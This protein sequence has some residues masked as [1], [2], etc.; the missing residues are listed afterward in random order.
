MRAVL[1]L[2]L[3]VF[4]FVALQTQSVFR[5]PSGRKYHAADC[6]TVKNVSEKISI[7]EA[8]AL[9]LTACL[10]CHPGTAEPATKAPQGEAPSVQ[11]KG[12]TLSG[13][14]C[15]LRTRIGNGYCSKHQPR[16]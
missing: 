3:F 15:K 14:R 1:F 5:T 16:E 9:G 10:V 4:G 6:R 13:T 2:I 11:C 8:R 12:L 7:E